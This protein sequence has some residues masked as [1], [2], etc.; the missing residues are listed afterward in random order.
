MLSMA[1]PPAM[2]PKRVCGPVGAGRLPCIS[3]SSK[4]GSRVWPLSMAW[5]MVFC[6]S[7]LRE[8]DWAAPAATQTA[9]KSQKAAAPTAAVI[10]GCMASLLR[11]L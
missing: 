9:T 1:M 11:S 8:M 2:K 6:A 5:R 10:S 7:R 4:A 3:F